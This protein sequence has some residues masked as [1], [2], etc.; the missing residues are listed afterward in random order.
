MRGV[1][2]LAARQGKQQ[3]VALLDDW[4]PS[5]PSLPETR[6]SARLALR[7]FTGH[8]PAT[9]QDLMWWSG[10]PAGAPASRH[11]ERRRRP[12]RDRRRRRQLL[13]RPGRASGRSRASTCCRTST[14]TWSATATAA[15][16]LDRNRWATSTR[17]RT[18]SSTPIV[19]I[20]GRVRG[21]WRRDVREGPRAGLRAPRSTASPSGSGAGSPRAPRA[22]ARFTGCPSSSGST[23]AL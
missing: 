20:D 23:R 8:G 19:V 21:T 11:R 17:A 2:C 12:R 13:G 4:A 3:T 6:R 18:G 10:L 9:V 14:S 15:R 5:A 7:Y 1:L 16:R 22:T